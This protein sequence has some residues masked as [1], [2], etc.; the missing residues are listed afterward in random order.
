MNKRW[1]LVLIALFALSVVLFAAY[2]ESGSTQI[3]SAFGLQSRDAP[4][5][6]ITRSKPICSSP[7]NP[8]VAAPT[9]CIPQYLANLPPDPGPEGMKTLEGIDSDKDGVRDDVQR[10]IAE[11]WGHSELAIRTL[12]VIAKSKQLQ[13][14]H[15]DSLGREESA[16]LVP[17]LMNAGVCYSRTSTPDMRKARAR[18]LVQLEVTN[19]PERFVRAGAFNYMIAHNVYLLGDESTAEACGFDPATL[20]N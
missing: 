5:S 9:D 16:K 1:L 4:R 19:T 12:T 6:A 11:N 18:E 8:N 15:G 10:Y 20:P 13:V 17:I 7:V 2:G 14:T 3:K